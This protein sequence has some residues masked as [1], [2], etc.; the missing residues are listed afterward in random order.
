MNTRLVIVWL[1]AIMI[2][3]GIGFFGM[4]NQ[5]LIGTDNPIENPPGVDPNKKTRTVSCVATAPDG[6]SS[7]S[8]T[9]DDSNGLITDVAITYQATTLVEARYTSAINLTNAEIGGV[10]MNM[11]GTGRDFVLIINANIARIDTKALD[12]YQTDLSNVHAIIERITDVDE[13]KMT[14]VN[15]GNEYNCN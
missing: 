13:Y 15:T 4:Y 9:I 1:I 10:S 5:H 6:N 3:A 7:Y 2:F 14:I 8:F 11:S 12:N